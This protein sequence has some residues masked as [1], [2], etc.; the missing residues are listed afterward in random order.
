MNVILCNIG[1]FGWKEIAGYYV[2]FIIRV[3]SGEELKFISVR[4]AET[5]LL[6]NY[7]H[8]LHAD[9]YTFTSVKSYFITDS[10]AKLLNEINKKHNDSIYGNDKFYA[11]KDY[12]VRLEDA[13]EFYTFIKVCYNKILSNITPGHIEKCGFIR[14][15]SEYVVPY[16]LKDD[17]KYLPLFYFDGEIELLSHCTVKLEDWNLAYL[18]FCC[19]VQGIK[20]ELYTN[21]V[22]T[23][24]TLDDIKKYFPQDTHFEEYWPAKVVNKQLLINPKST[25][26][27]PS[28][29]WI[30]APP[31]VPASESTISPSLIASAPVMPQSMPVVMN[32]FK[33][34][35][36][37]NRLVCIM[38]SVY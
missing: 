15:N 33:N 26:V 2:P 34:G 12:I 5:Q 37:P 32:T 3:I 9:I 22:C 6:S 29:V 35:W 13:L 27:H 31:G 4:M 20:T 19:N 28:G 17:H 16:C 25:Y 21:D 24:I 36:P 11:G 10:E 8:N 18:Q 14:I 30:R 1:V 23:A 7:L 38:Y